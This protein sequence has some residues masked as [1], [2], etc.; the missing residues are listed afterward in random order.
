MFFR[1][2]A[3]YHHCFTIES[4]SLANTVP[5]Y[6]LQYWVYASQLRL[7]ISVYSFNLKL[8]VRFIKN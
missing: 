1:P 8:E 3:F 7:S 6:Y 4:V 2:T 5:D